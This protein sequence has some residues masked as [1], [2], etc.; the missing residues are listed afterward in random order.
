MKKF[1]LVLMI[2]VSASIAFSQEAEFDFS[3]LQTI[4]AESDPWQDLIDLVN[5]GLEGLD[6]TDHA[7][8]ELESKIDMLTA[9]TEDQARLLA[10][11]RAVIRDLRRQLREARE[12][13][14]I[15]VDRMQDAEQVGAWFVAEA[16]RQMLQLRRTTEARKRAWIGALIVGGGFSATGAWT[17]HGVTSGN[18]TPWS[19]AP[20]VGSGAIWLLGHLLYWW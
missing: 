11:S 9:E 12:S 3:D 8:D 1:L 19:A 7:I 15:A 2:F 10:E 13:V 17:A 6:M 4:E 18:Y 5:T 14:E 20:A 16:E